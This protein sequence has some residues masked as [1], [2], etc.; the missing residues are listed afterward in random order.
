MRPILH[1]IS[2]LRTGGAETMLVALCRSLQARGLPQHV[3]SLTR[4]GENAEALAAAG[5]TVHVLA[6]GGLAGAAA[7]LL[8][9]SRLIRR[10]R[11]AVIQ[12]W[13]YHGDLFAALAHRLAGAPRGSLLAWG[14]RN[15]DIDHA[16]YGRLLRIGRA[17]SGWPG[18]VVSNS[19][20]GADFHCGLGYRPRRLAVIPNG[21]DTVRFRP[22]TAARA[23]IRAELGIPEDAVV[24]IHAARLDPMKDHG[25]VLAAAALVPQLRFVLAGAGT[26]TLALPPNAIALGRRDDLPRLYAAADIVLSTSAFGEGFSN[27]L[28]EGMAAG[29][30]P[31][32]TRVG[33]AALILSGSGRLVPPGDPAAVASALADFGA[34]APIARRETGLAAR[35][36]IVRAFGIDAMAAGFLEAWTQAGAS[37]DPA[38][39]RSR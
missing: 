22:D 29:L 1:V 37:L 7:S 14:W 30:V 9:L 25:A 32:A 6:P 27:A 10:L 21:I 13:L 35:A 4:G 36:R 20:A 26:E 12:G 16:R 31:V 18:L 15:S 11:P 3:V 33:D 17:L 8:S 28:A 23:V 2:G 24:V 38:A 19:Q 34:L 39:D 5:V